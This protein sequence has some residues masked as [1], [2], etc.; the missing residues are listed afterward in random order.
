LLAAA[1]RQLDAVAGVDPPLDALAERLR[2]LAIEADDVAVE[3]HRYLDGAEGEPDRL[4]QV[5]QRLEAFARLERKHGGTIAAVL[6]HAEQCRARRDELRGAEA[7]L[8]ET[9]AA[10]TAAREQLSAIAGELHD[11][12]AAAA[13]ALAEAVRARLAELAMPDARFEVEIAPREEPGPTGGDAVELLIAANPGVPAGPLREVASGGE[14]SR[15]MLA[16]LG[17]AN[18]D[19]ESA[20]RLLVFDEVDAG[21]GG[22]TANAVGAQLHALAAD[23]QVLCITHLPQVAAH[24]D[25]HFRIAKDGSGGTATTTVTALRRDALV[26]ELVRMLGADEADRAARR[27]ARELLKAA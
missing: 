10:L 13:P 4:E 12:R 16:L 25:R 14:L 2:G 27:H 7:A 1:G 21:I 11:A 8:A 22:H 17:V 23:R 18:A 9:T 19:V 5:E 20:A 26:A 15:V 6:A 3:L 24:A